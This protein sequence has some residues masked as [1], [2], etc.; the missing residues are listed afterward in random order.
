MDRNP[1][2]DKLSVSGIRGLSIQHI[3]IHLKIR[4][5][6]HLQPNQRK[7]YHFLHHL[8]ISLRK[9]VINQLAFWPMIKM[10]LQMRCLL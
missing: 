2:N 1:L 8:E 6:I 3:N 10:N 4:Q 9:M 7:R 5:L